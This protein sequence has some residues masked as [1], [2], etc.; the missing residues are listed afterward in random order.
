MSAVGRYGAGV[1]AHRVVVVGALTSLVLAIA[2]C[3]SASPSV[4]PSATVPSA[5]AVPSW[6]VPIFGQTGQQQLILTSAWGQYVK[7]SVQPSLVFD[8]DL[9]TIAVGSADEIQER[10]TLIGA[11]VQARAN[12]DG[13]IKAM[14]ER[15][16]DTEMPN[17]VDLLTDEQSILATMEKKLLDSSNP[18]SS[19]T[20]DE[21]ELVVDE[22]NAADLA[23][24]FGR[25]F[26]GF[27][28][29]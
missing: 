24:S 6:C 19:L 9:S 21:G 12:V 4:A 5:A 18:V 1:G 28:A 26:C 20:V 2:G 29:S 22:Q 14:A 16:A 15:G 7:A 3:G 27:P 23:T 11:V 17:L 8:R 10:G 13:L 25:T